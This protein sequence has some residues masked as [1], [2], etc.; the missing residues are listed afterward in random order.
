M[1]NGRSAKDSSFSGVLCRFESYCE[2]SLNIN[3][4]AKI[5]YNKIIKLLDKN[6]IS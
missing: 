6:E 4:N 3:T 1:E 5:N 2:Y